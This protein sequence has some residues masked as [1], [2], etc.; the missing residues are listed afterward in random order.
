MVKKEFISPEDTAGIIPTVLLSGPAAL[1]F[2][3]PDSTT[4]DSVLIDD[5]KILPTL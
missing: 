3:T 5:L 2:S 1:V 4:V